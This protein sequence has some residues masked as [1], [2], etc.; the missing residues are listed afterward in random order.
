MSLWTLV[1]AALAPALGMVLMLASTAQAVNVNAASFLSACPGPIFVPS[2]TTLVGSATV[3]GDCTVSSSGFPGPQFNLSQATLTFTGFFNVLGNASSLTVDRS[4]VTTGG[5]LV[6]DSQ[7][8]MTI[9]GTKLSAGGSV[10]LPPRDG[11]EVTH[12][13]IAAS[14]D[15]TVGGQGGVRNFTDSDISAGNV[16]NIAAN[17]SQVNVLHSNLPAGIRITLGGGLTAL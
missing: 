16:I 9:S 11:L 15:V 13:S 2:D 6:V 8:L 14:G 12:S 4:K 10:N 17:P 1:R 5:D 3:T 7:G